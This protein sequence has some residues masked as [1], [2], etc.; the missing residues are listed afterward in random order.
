MTTAALLTATG[1]YVVLALLSS[2]Y[3]G[4]KT[5]PLVTLNWQHYSGFEG[6]WG[7]DYRHRPW[8]ATAIQL[9]I[10]FFP[11]FDMLSVFPLVGIS[12][13]IRIKNQTD[14]LQAIAFSRLYHQP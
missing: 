4:K 1:F 5:T 3:F 9:W 6:G 11:V 12:L 14:Y 2:I 8:W 7:G 13:G 10:M